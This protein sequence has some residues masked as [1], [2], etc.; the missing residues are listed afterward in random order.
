MKEIIIMISSTSNYKYNVQQLSSA[1]PSF[2]SFENGIQFQSL[3]ARSIGNNTPKNDTIQSIEVTSGD[4]V[5]VSHIVDNLCHECS[6]M[7]YSAVSSLV[8]MS[9][10]SELSSLARG[11]AF[12]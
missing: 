6:L 4:I 5:T 3:P 2:I 9:L 8:K 12:E 10:R 1:S 7:R 11:P